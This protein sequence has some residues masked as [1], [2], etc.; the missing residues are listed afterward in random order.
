MG[1]I[2]LTV[3]LFALCG[4]W[5]SRMDGGGK[6][7]TPEIVEKIL[8][9]IPY[10][11][12]GFLLAWPIGI[13]CLAAAWGGRALGHGQYFLALGC[14][15]LSSERYDFILGLFFP[16]DPRTDIRFE[17]L[18]DI[19]EDKLTYEQRN[20][21]ANA[22]TVYGMDR[23]WIRCFV[24]LCISGL[25][26]T[27]I[28]ALFLALYGH[29]WFAGALVLSGLLKGPCYALG[30]GKTEIGELLNG[31]QQFLIGGAVIVGLLT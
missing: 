3:L 18:R 17:A 22:M 27:A 15:A 5:F 24:G 16:P 30:R 31:F 12:I 9:G 4:A 21:I 29:L 7:R 19:D 13:I 11:L 6:P 8:C 23:L 28:P 26:V 1:Y 25:L 20:M 10:T 2:V 14:K